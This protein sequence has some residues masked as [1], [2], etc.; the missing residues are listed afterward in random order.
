MRFSPLTQ[1]DSDS[2]FIVHTGKN[3]N[4]K[5]GGPLCKDLE[6]ALAQ[7]PHHVVSLQGSLQSNIRGFVD[8]N[9]IDVVVLGED[10]PR[11]GGLQIQSVSD[12][13]RSNISCPFII[14]RPSAVRNE[15]LRLDSGFHT[16][17][18]PM[19]PTR[20]LSPE[21]APSRK[22][23]IAYPTFPIGLHLFELAKQL[24]L[25][26]QDEIFVVHCFQS[27]KGV[28]KHTKNLLRAMSIGL[29]SA[30]GTDTVKASEDVTEDNFVDFGAKELS[31]YNV[32][33]NV[34][35]RGDVKSSLASFC[36]HEGIELLVISTRMASRIRKTLSGGSVS[37]YLID[38]APCPC[39]VL[40]LKAMG[41]SVADG[42]DE[43]RDAEAVISP[44]SS[45]EPSRW[46]LPDQDQNSLSTSM[47]KSIE[48][49]K[50]QVAER[51]QLIENL[52]EE[53]SAL[54]RVIEVN[55]IKHPAVEVPHVR[56]EK[57][58]EEK[59]SC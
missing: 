47:L 24:V 43:E 10:F 22:V 11:Q 9:G 45:L 18:E 1:R 59:N 13:V 21:S 52:Q 58:E 53:I 23:A 32:H 20:Q 14:I 35:L 34:V 56:V 4:W 19:S 41:V 42:E 57:G 25:L 55:K 51:N 49:L 54:R 27:D 5:A 12:W 48:M 17:G 28:V 33:L 15:R 8:R 39:L 40:P 16:G 36:E 31:G 3:E 38:H 30:S 29:P 50:R 46:G 37:G 7:W 2:L 26:P 6:T 44:N